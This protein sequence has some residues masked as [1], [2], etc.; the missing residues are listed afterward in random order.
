MN[1]PAYGVFEKPRP[2]NLRYIYKV[3]SYKQSYYSVVKEWENG[4]GQTVSE[5]VGVSSDSDGAKAIWRLCVS[6]M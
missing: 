2:K 1:Y 4:I 5:E 6:N 3:P